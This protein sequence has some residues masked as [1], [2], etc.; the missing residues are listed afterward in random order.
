[1]ANGTIDLIGW[2]ISFILF[3]SNSKHTLHPSMVGAA[4]P[5]F[6]SLIP[7]PS[8][9]SLISTEPVELLC[10]ASNISST[11][12]FCFVK[13]KQETV[14]AFLQF[15]ANMC[16]S[17]QRAQ[18]ENS[19]RLRLPHSLNNNQAGGPILRPKQKSEA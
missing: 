4:A 11:D 9:P 1:M 3:V 16:S 14:E 18:N 12:P 15:L 19:R 8:V 13:Q 17:A 5:G 10:R 7:A 6:Y 2:N